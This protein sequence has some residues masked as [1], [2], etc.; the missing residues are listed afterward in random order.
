MYRVF[1]YVQGGFVRLTMVP[2]DK[3]MDKSAH[4][5][6]AF[7]YACWGAGVTVATKEEST[8]DELGYSLT[9]EDGQEHDLDALAYYTNIIKIPDVIPD[10]KY[11][12]GTSCR[13]E[14]LKAIHLPH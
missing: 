6:F 1:L 10:G 9:Q 5:K 7:H 12:L 4:D 2:L 13:P 14:T 11:V 8:K 3:M